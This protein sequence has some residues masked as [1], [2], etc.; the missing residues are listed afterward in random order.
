M[1]NCLLNFTFEELQNLIVDLGEKKFRA[2]QIYKSLHL[3]LDFSEMTDISKAF[4]ERLS[5]DYDAQT[6]RIIKHLESCFRWL[7]GFYMRSWESVQHESVCR[8]SRFGAV[9]G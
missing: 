1:K 2:G 4:R 5:Q 6:V 8:K 3:G 9:V 7:G